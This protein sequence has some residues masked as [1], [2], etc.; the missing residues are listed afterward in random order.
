MGDLD[1]WVSGSDD[2]TM[3]VWN[4]VDP[5]ECTQALSLPG[6][7]TALQVDNM[8]RVLVVASQNII[9]VYDIFSWR[10]LQ[11]HRSYGGSI[12]NCLLLLPERNQ[13]LSGGTDG[14]IQLWSSHRLNTL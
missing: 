2:S 9:Q 13:Y 6:P 4:S 7:V 3:R 1:S 11:R 14:S 12:I 10:I 5:M 8:N